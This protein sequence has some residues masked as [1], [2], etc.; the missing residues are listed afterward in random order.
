MISVLTWG[1][2]ALAVCGWV[3]VCALAVRRFVLVRLERRRGKAELRLRRVALA[4]L[5]GESVDLTDLN[6]DDADVLATVLGR[7]GRNLRGATTARIASFFERQ[8]EVYRQLEALGSRRPWR[9]ATAAFVLGDMGSRQ[10]IASLR[11]ALDDPDLAVRSAAARSLGRLGEPTAVEPLVQALAERRIPRSVAGQALLAIGEP[12]LPVLRNLV[13]APEPEARG[14]AVE[15]V[16]LLGAASDGAELV[17]RLR[18]S[19][20]E[21]RANAAHALGKLGAEEGAAELRGALGDRIPFVRAAVARALGVVGDA[22]VVPE[23]LQVARED[24]FDPARAAAGAAARLDPAAVRYAA[25]VPGAGP[26]L[27]EA[28]DLVE[29]AG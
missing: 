22:D 14:L 28:A 8:G 19:S 15:L 1:A 18:D 25:A 2:A 11:A 16:G 21:V 17:G 4:L 23:L 9:R 5:E 24:S 10:G 27:H 20:A 29:M 6:G 12:A 26:H 7:F 13:R 3:S